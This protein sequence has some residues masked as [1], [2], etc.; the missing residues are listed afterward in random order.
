[1][2]DDTLSRPLVDPALRRRRRIWIAIAVAVAFV[3]LVV[4]HLV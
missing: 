4:A 2:T 3:L 1:M